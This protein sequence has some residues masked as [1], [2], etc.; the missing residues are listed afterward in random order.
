MLDAA[1]ELALSRSPEDAGTPASRAAALAELAGHFPDEERPEDVEL[2]R[3]RE[4]DRLTSQPGTDGRVA[5][6][7]RRHPDM[8]AEQP[9]RGLT[10]VTTVEDEDPTDHAAPRRGAVMHPEVERILRQHGV[11]LGW[12]QNTTTRP[13]SAAQ[14]EAEERRARAGHQAGRFSIQELH[15]AAM[16]SAHSSRG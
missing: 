5:D 11:L 9:R 14:R 12:D 8:L 13:K 3:Q 2:A 6:L 10:H 15:R 7:V 1:T 4:I 16:R